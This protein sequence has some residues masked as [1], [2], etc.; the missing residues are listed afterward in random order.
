MVRARLSGWAQCVWLSNVLQVFNKVSSVMRDQCHS[1]LNASAL[2]HKPESFKMPRISQSNNRQ[3]K[4]Q[5][6]SLPLR[7]AFS[8]WSWT[9]L[10]MSYGPWHIVEQ[11]PNL[12]GLIQQEI[13]STHSTKTDSHC[14]EEE[15]WYWYQVRTVTMAVRVISKSIFMYGLA[16]EVCR[17]LSMIIPL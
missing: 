2:K 12:P 5:H 11:Y 4:N 15:P 14:T 16:C 7:R 10:L 3:G 8:H 1:G 9:L 6:Q 17:K 13:W